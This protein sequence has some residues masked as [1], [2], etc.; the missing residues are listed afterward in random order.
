MKIIF[1]HIPKTA[2]QSVHAALVNAYGPDAVCPARVNEQLCALSVSEINRYKVF[3]GHLDWSALDCVKGDK[4][5]FTV[6]REPMDRVLSFYFY[7]RDQGAGLTP[8]KRARPEHQGLKAAF[9]L[10]PRDYFLGGAPQLRNFLDDHYDNFY[11]NFF[12]GRHYKA[13]SEFAGLL[14]RKVLSRQDLL[15]IAKDNITQLDAVFTVNEMDKV[16]RSIREWSGNAAIADEGFRVNVNR[17]VEPAA[18]RERLCSLG[19]DE[20]TMERLNA[21]CE[22][23]NELW[24]SFCASKPQLAA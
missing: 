3:S 1:L 9:E 6:L 20:A 8:E 2:G 17:S 5:V 21:Y 23:D 24:A 22:L 10:S 19:A 4:Q 16:F 11:T 13:R 12:A 14:T 15:R 18:R 7:L